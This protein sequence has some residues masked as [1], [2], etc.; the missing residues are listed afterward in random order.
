MLFT[1][2]KTHYL[3]DR[4]STLRSHDNKTTIPPGAG[5]G[6]LPPHAYKT[7]TELPY[8]FKEH[9]I[10]LITNKEGKESTTIKIE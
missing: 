7:F 9:G 6:S 1:F 4:I 2:Y 3:P 10:Y 8:V 5:S